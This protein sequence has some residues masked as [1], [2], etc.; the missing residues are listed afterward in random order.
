MRRRTIVAVAL[1]LAV[2]PAIASAQPQQQ[3]PPAQ[4]GPPGPAAGAPGQ[5]GIPG[6]GPQLG[7]ILDRLNLTPEQ[8]TS[9]TTIVAAH[10]K[11]SDNDRQ[12]IIK[13]RELLVKQVNA[14]TFD[15]G[16]IRQAAAAVA[17]LDANR[18]VDSAKFLKEVRGVLS[19]EQQKQF[20]EALARPPQPQGAGPGGQAPPRARPPGS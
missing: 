18:A 9:I 15:E 6:L 13:A 3:P 7:R 1:L 19:P 5:P 16:A 10:K 4:P 20:Q 2:G 17:A 8:R 11:T 12:Q 14:P